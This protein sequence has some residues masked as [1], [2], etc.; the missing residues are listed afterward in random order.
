MKKLKELDREKNA[1]KVEKI[2]EFHEQSTS[3]IKQFY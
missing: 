2:K 1:K 3:R